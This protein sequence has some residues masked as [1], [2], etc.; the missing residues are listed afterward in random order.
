MNE[1]IIVSYEKMLRVGCDRLIDGDLTLM[2]KHK[3]LQT[4]EGLCRK[5]RQ[6]IENDVIEKV[7]NAL[8]S[9]T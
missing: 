8:F 9:I 1:R 4:M 3:T 7:D 5:L 2:Q 6:D